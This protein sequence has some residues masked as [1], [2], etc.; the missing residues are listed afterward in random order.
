MAIE[1]EVIMDGC[2]NG[3]KFLKRDI[4]SE[5][6]H[7]SLSSSERLM[8][9]FR[10]VVQPSRGAPAITYAEVRK[11]RSARTKVVGNDTSR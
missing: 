7:G 6:L 5:T 10:P 11:R 1:V 4:A 9:I 8:G 3:D 2:V